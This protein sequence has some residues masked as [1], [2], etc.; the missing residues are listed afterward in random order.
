M[1]FTCAHSSLKSLPDTHT[2]TIPVTVT[3]DSHDLAGL[4]RHAAKQ[5]QT[6]EVRPL[7]VGQ[8]SPQKCMCVCVFTRSCQRSHWCMY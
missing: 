1:T 4:L 7:V 6:L 2:H 5:G 8:H 3:V